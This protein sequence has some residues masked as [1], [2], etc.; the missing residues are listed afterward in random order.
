MNKLYIIKFRLYNDYTI[1][2]WYGWNEFDAEE[3][4]KE[5]PEWTFSLVTDNNIHKIWDAR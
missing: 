3:K 5:N 1:S 4:M 2:T